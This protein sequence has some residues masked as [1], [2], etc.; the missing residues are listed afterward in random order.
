[1]CTGAWRTDFDVALI[2]DSVKVEAFGDV[3]LFFGNRHMR[4]DFL[5]QEELRRFVADRTLTCLHTAFSRDQ[6]GIGGWVGACV[7]GVGGGG[8][9]RGKQGVT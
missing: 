8:R 1:M 2:D 5:Y 4:R 7:G 3:V 6:V 9:A